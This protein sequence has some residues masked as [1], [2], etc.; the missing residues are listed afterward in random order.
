MDEVTR[1]PLI[2]AAKCFKK[3]AATCDPALMKACASGAV[4]EVARLLDRVTPAIRDKVT[5][6]SRLIVISQCLANEARL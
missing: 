5:G 4:A 6:T 3:K 1:Q 2:K